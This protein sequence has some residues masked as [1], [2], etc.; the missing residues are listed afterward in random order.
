MFVRWM[1][2]RMSI[3]LGMCFLVG[4][5]LFWGVSGVQAERLKQIPTVS[6]A[7]VTGTPVGAVAVVMDSEQGFANVRAGPSTKDYEAVGVLTE[8]SQVPALGRSPGGQWVMIA[9]PGAPGGVGWVYADLVQVRGGA[10]PIVEP[11]P[12]PTPRTTATIN[13][14]LAAQFLVEVPPTRLPTFTAPQPLQMPTYQADAPLTS[15]GR[16]P[17]GLVIIVMAVLGLIGVLISFLRGR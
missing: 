8:G 3:L 6:I 4:S 7:T 17:M 10:L 16:A 12:T 9:Y 2:A 1:H 14:T 13:P 5:A 11:P 15:S